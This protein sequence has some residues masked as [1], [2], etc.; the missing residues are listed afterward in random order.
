MRRSTEPELL[1]LPANDAAMLRGNLRDM[2]HYD[3]RLGTFSLALRLATQHLRDATLALDVGMGNGAFMQFAAP[4]S[5]LRWAGVDASPAV[6]AIAQETCA[7]PMIAAQGQRLP[8]ADKRFDV[9]VCANTLHH[10]NDED[11]V[12]LL[13]ECARVTRQRVVIVD[14]ARSRLTLLGAWLLTRLTSRNAMTLADGV[15]SARRAWTPAEARAVVARAGMAQARVH[16]HGPF[17][18][19]ITIAL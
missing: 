8:F 10:L 17:H 3:R 18:F 13:H 2:A 16:R 19:S 14:L 5:A 4:R 6:I 1:D 11:A 12:L 7:A 15:Q 9:V